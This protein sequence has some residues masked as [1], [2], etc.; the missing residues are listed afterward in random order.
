MP[1]AEEKEKSSEKRFFV[2]NHCEVLCSISLKFK[3]GS[4]FSLFV[5]V[6][7]FFLSVFTDVLIF[8]CIYTIDLQDRCRQCMGKKVVRERKILEVYITKGMKDGQK[9]TFTGEGDQVNDNLIYPRN[10]G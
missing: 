3:K 5:C 9:I 8:V 7:K 2:P 10:F 4:A 1:T 6:D